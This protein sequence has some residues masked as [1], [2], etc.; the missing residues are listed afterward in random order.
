MLG[1]RPLIWLGI[2]ADGAGELLLGETRVRAVRQHVL[3]GAETR[4]G[5]GGRGRGK[6]CGSYRW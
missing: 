5:G 4:S 6:L 3:E 1:P 2:D